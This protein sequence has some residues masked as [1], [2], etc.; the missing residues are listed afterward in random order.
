MIPLARGAAA[1]AAVL[2]LLAVGTSAPASAATA[3]SCPASPTALDAAGASRAWSI[4]ADRLAALDGPATLPFG[5]T[6]SSPYLRTGPYAWTSG[7]YAASL[8]RMYEHTREDVWLSRAR[9]YTDRVLPVAV[10]RGSHDLGF[11]V[12][13]PARLGLQ[14][15]PSGARSEAYARAILDASR[16]LSS[17]WNGRV[18]AIRSA[19]Y[20]GRWGLIIDSAMNAPLLIEAGLVHGGTE[21]RRLSTRGLEHMRTLARTFIRSDGSTVHRQ[22]FDPRTGR[23]LGPVYGQGLST[24]STWARGQAWAVAGF[25][26]AFLLTGDPGML[27]AARRTADLWTARVPGGCV[28]AWDLDVT[29]PAAPRDS[30]A[31]AIAAEGLLTLASVDPDPARAARHREHALLTL[32]T[33]VGAPWMTDAGRGV[34]KRQ[35]YNI[36]ADAREGTYSW[37]DAYLLAA[38][39]AAGS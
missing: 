4:A 22:A 15:D 23:L 10:W 3:V 12:G 28:P 30:S 8:W 25:S 17:R 20:G 21:G 9:A 18:Q 38:L 26:R 36:P 37:G 35:A 14:A 5:A 6:G 39:V 31:A 13:L 24:R 32:G 2:A 33:L 19:Y 34:L 16:S 11:M 29:D 7:F 1:V 27:D